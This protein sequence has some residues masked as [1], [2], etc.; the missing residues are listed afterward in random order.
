MSTYTLIAFKPEHCFNDRGDD[1]VLPARLVREDELT[2]EQV[3]DRVL[4]LR[5]ERPLVEYKWGREP[6]VPFEEFHVFGEEA[7]PLD[8]AT[9][10]QERYDAWQQE[11]HPT[12]YARRREWEKRAREQT[13]AILARLGHA[14]DTT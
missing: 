13:H 5:T 12:E 10:V 9:K 6:D 11:H 7:A 14:K 2:R 3:V 4:A 8:V 1:V